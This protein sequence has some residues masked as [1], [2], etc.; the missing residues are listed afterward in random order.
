MFALAL[1]LV[2]PVFL[3]L[4]NGF[5]VYKMNVNSPILLLYR[6]AIVFIG[7]PVL[8][9]IKDKR[10]VIWLLLL[11]AL[12]VVDMAA[13]FVFN[14]LSV[15]NEVSIFIRV[16]YPYFVLG[17][18]LLFIERK[19]LKLTDMVN[20]QLAYCVI[21]AV[22]I[23]LSF[24]F[25]VGIEYG[26]SK[27]SFGTKSFFS[28]QNDTSLALLIGFI[29]NGGMILTTLK[30]RYFLI[31]ILIFSSLIALSTRSGIMGAI[32]VAGVLV[33]IMFFSGYGQVR[34]HRYK[35]NMIFLIS[36]LLMVVGL[37]GL[38]SVI[39][40]YHYL[41]TK[42]ET[43]SEEQP[44]EKLAS[45]ALRRIVARPAAMNVFGEGRTSFMMELGR[46]MQGLRS[47]LKED[48]KTAEVDYM[49]LM[50]N[51]GILFTI[52]VFL[53]P[54]WVWLKC[55]LKVLFERSV[56]SA[57]YL[58][59]MSIFLI[60]SFLAGHAMMSPVVGTAI[61]LVYVFVLTVG[62]VKKPRKQI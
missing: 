8:F 4:L 24:A 47:R 1:I 19:W 59:A 57:V 37:I 60:H 45:G 51:Y 31:G 26:G 54:F 12:F 20:L 34:V 25:G 6:G 13:W 10:H 18:L 7:L 62:D 9:M 30:K 50:G 43:L 46:E 33:L 61:S 36:V 39:K 32:G 41:I 52:W 28:A 11:T 21:A 2:I 17:I 29:F 35:K 14:S 15:G 48:G 40:E 38:V 58:M 44:R 53:F 16:A 5:L 55:A 56:W 27:F 49:D 3:D 22:S 23:L 42:F